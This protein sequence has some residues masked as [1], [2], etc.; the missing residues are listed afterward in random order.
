MHKA[1]SLIA[2]GAM[3][4]LGVI[5]SAVQ[6]HSAYTEQKLNEWLAGGDKEPRQVLFQQKDPKNPREFGVCEKSMTHKD[7]MGTMLQQSQGAQCDYTFYIDR[8]SGAQEK[9]SEDERGVFLVR[10]CTNCGEVPGL[11][12]SSQVSMKPE[13][14]FFDFFPGVLKQKTGGSSQTFTF[15]PLNLVIQKVRFHQENDTP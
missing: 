3:V 11:F 2:R 12:F 5:G 7:V 15:T 4:L 9:I 10:A 1:Y 8:T 14:T 13:Y 6:V